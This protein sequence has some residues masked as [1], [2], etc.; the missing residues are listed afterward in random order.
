M[1]VIGN[2]STRSY[3]PGKERNLH[4]IGRDLGVR[5]LLEGTV[6]R[7]QDQMRVALPLVNLRDGAIQWHLLNDTADPSRYVEYI[8][9]ESWVEHLRQHERVTVADRAVQDYARSFHVG[10]QPPVISH[11]IAENV[12]NPRTKT[13]A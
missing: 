8:V 1:K 10:A 3:P 6:S 2:Q 4:A 9:V 5:H 13:G 11:F 12:V 7:D